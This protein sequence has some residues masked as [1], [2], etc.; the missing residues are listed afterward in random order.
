MNEYLDGLNMDQFDHISEISQYN[1][2]Y[3]KG[4]GNDLLYAESDDDQTT[5]WYLV[6]KNGLMDFKFIGV[7]FIDE[8][9]LIK[10]S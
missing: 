8:E 1:H 5:E 4:F 7:S 10:K 2:N 3:Y 9:I 6:N